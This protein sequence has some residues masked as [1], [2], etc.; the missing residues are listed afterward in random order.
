MEYKDAFKEYL[1]WKSYKGRKCKVC[2]RNV[3][4]IFDYRD[5]I[6][7]AQCGDINEPCNLDMQLKRGEYIEL[8][9]VDIYRREQEIKDKMIDLK[10]KFIFD[11]I[12]E[13]EMVETFESL[14][15]EYN[16]IIK[17]RL[18]RGREVIKNEEEKELQ[19]CIEDI[20]EKVEHG[21]VRDAIELY[22]DNILPLLDQIRNKYDYITVDNE[23]KTEMYTDENGEKKENTVE[24]KRL[25]KRQK[26]NMI[27]IRAPEIIAFTKA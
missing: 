21:N 9:E 1:E 4:M 27:E 24:Y 16:T 6:Y 13:T 23:S 12:T 2:K 8:D 3:G 19:E 18:L 17:E 11:R 20:K 26:R 25:I 10:V 5:N 7:T 14:K 22:I 15:S